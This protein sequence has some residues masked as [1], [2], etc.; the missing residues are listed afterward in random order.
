MAGKVGI[1]PTLLRLT[2]ERF[3]FKLLAN[4]GELGLEPRYD[5]SKPPVLPLD[6]S[7]IRNRSE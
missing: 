6:D 7:P 3:A 1:E 4:A 2:T 5:G